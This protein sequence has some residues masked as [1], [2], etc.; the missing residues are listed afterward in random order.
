MLTY[1]HMSKDDEDR[2]WHLIVSIYSANIHEHPVETRIFFQVASISSKNLTTCNKQNFT[3]LMTSL[4]EG[5]GEFQHTRERERERARAHACANV[6]VSKKAHAHDLIVPH[7][8]R[9]LQRL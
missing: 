4:G 3:T 5:R 7:A 1:T 9:W 6:Y 2:H 8:E